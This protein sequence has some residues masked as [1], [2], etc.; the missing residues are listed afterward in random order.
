MNTRYRAQGERKIRSTIRAM[1]LQER[2][3]T[4]HVLIRTGVHGLA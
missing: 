3:L 4:F 1:G 2:G